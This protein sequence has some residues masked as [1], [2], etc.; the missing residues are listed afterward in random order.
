MP[1]S[2]TIKIARI[3]I[4][5]VVI[6]AIGFIW[7]KRQHSHAVEL[8]VSEQFV[9]LLRAE[10]YS[11]AYELTMKDRMWGLQGEGFEAYAKRQVCGNLVVTGVFPHQSNGNRLR[12][13]INGQPVDMESVNIQYDGTCPFR[14]TL[15]RNAAG[16][17][18]VF[19]FGSHAG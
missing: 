3:G 5:F 17:W 19:M 4:V 10:D 14:V 12:R 9:G 2:L 16:E 6:A 15:R 1:Q 8:R 7:L 18:K 11:R 13:I